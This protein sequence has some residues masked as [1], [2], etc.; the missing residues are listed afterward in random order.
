[1]RKILRLT[2][3]ASLPVLAVG[4]AACRNYDVKYAPFN[5]RQLQ[6]DER[7][8]AGPG[9]AR[10][11]RPLPTTLEVEYPLRGERVEEKVPP[12]TGPAIGTTGERVV[13]MSLREMVQRGVANS[14]DVKVASYTPAIEQ[15]RV[16]EAEARF[17]PTF[18]TN[19]QYSQE[20]VLGPSATN[21]GADTDIT[22][23]RT[24]SAQIGLRQ[25]LESGG[26]V[27][28]R[29]E[30]AHTERAPND[31]SAFGGGISPNPFWTSE[32]TLQV[33]QPLLR[34]FGADVNR[35]RIEINRNNQRIGLADYREQLEKNVSDTERTYW[36]LVQAMRDVQIADELLRRTLST[37]DLLWKRRGQDVGRQQLSQANS[38]IETRR[39]ILIRA[40]A[41]V[42]DLS[43]QLKRLI[44]D[45]EFPVASNILIL[46]A[47]QALGEEVQ[48][49]EVDQINTAMENRHELGQQQL[50]VDNAGIAADVAKNNLLPQLNMVG[51]L[52]FQGLDE[53]WPGA[54][55]EQ[56]EFNAIDYTIG[57]Q[58]EIPIGNRAARAIWKRAQ[59][60]RLQAID[61]YRALI[62]EV[63][64]NVRIALRQVQTTWDE[65]YGSR[66][67]TLAAADA[68]AAIEEREKAE[69][70]GLTPEFVNRK[71]DL[72]AELAQNE[73]REAEAM[74]NY[75]V[76][77]SDL[78]RAKGTLLRYNNIIMEEASA[79]STETASTAT[80]APR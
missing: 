10:P 26:R 68:L 62:D 66:R 37:G 1:M 56:W 63:S 59:L 4:L 19:I 65:I 6:E 39:T 80:P 76:A 36:Q 32:L 33:T 9:V 38:S 18:F 23:F 48:F 17:D 64:L 13:R 49:N 25:D 73:S 71:L 46:P 11:D 51:S 50:R 75:M 52:G 3:W 21:I 2:G 77:I 34:D 70:A 22:T 42:R 79:E 15:T 16:T 53:D 67:A 14:L 5:P 29:Y 72:Q 55:G 41:R 12:A 40:R 47:D 27:E 54:V 24:Y 74:S 57:L 20:N 60:Q 31:T 61:Q 58:L 78:E 45:P 69:Q 8:A 30:P 35:A 43:D 44:N 28:V 7:Q